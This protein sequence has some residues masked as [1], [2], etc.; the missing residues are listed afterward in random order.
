[1]K[2][3]QLYEFFGKSELSKLYLSD[4]DPNK[5]NFSISGNEINYIDNDGNK[6]NIIK[7]ER[8]LNVYPESYSYYFNGKEKRIHKRSGRN[9]YNFLKKARN[10]FLNQIK[11]YNL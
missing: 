4:I 3:L 6:Y 9:L 1:M 10:E 5:I 8:Y 2:H 7:T 11:K